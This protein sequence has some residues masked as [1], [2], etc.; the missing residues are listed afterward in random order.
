MDGWTDT[1]RQVVD[2]SDHA[3]VER[4]AAAAA[5]AIAHGL[6]DLPQLG[7]MRA[8]SA[9]LKAALA[10]EQRAEAR[11]RDAEARA[12]VAQEDL[13]AAFRPRLEEAAMA[14]LRAG[15]QPALAAWADPYATDA[16]GRAQL[17]AVRSQLGSAPPGLAAETADLGAVV[18]AMEAAG[19]A[20]DRAHQE[21]RQAIAL[22]VAA[23]RRWN[24]SVELI[25]ASLD[26]EVVAMWLAGLDV[27]SHAGFAEEAW[28][29]DEG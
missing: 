24:A 4:T 10:N 23:R 22:R 28:F 27:R 17:E 8:A 2:W 6:S 14:G 9:E 1:I 18:D 13:L 20:R 16:T 29:E 21:R 7:R 26:G 12:V 25:L 19:T 5:F 15:L 3:A 11:D